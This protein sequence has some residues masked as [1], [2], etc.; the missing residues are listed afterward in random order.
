MKEDLAT[1]RLPLHPS[2]LCPPCGREDRVFMMPSIRESGKSS[3]FFWDFQTT[4]GF[5]QFLLDFRNSDFIWLWFDSEMPCTGFWL[6]CSWASF[7][8]CGGPLRSE[9]LTVGSRSLDTGLSRLGKSFPGLIQALSASWF[10]PWRQLLWCKKPL[11][12]APTGAIPLCL[13]SYDRSRF[14]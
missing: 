12:H 10:L 14:H 7:G 4:V 11:P 1:E 2:C 3:Y 13:P 5:L 8:D 9:G 6:E